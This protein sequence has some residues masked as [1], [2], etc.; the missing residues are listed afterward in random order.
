MPKN[1]VSRWGWRGG[2]LAGV[3]AVALPLALMGA[4][5]PHLFALLRPAMSA[6]MFAGQRIIYSYSG[7]TPPAGLLQRIEAGEAAGVIFFAG[8]NPRAAAATPALKQ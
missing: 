5:S 8:E 3:L 2:A 1:G 7:L 4:W 6:R